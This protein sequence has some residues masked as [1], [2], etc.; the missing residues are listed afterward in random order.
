VLLFGL[1]GLF[2]KWLEL[3]PVLI[4]LGRTAIAAAALAAVRA[5][6]NAERLPRLPCHASVTT[7]SMPVAR[8]N[9]AATLVRAATT[10]DA[11]GKAR[12]RC[13]KS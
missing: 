10:K 3:P 1:S 5:V 11:S 8:S 4:V 9:T 2:G 6:R 12:R 13:S 7:A